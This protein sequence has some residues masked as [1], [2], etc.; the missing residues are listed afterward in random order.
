MKA[1]QPRPSSASRVSTGHLAE[2]HGERRTAARLRPG[3]AAKPGCTATTRSTTIAGFDPEV[4][5]PK[6]ELK[7]TECRRN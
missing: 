7:S 6:V 4:G 3:Y 2:R 5:Q 1:P